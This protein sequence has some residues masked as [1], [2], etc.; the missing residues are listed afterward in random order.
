MLAYPLQLI[1]KGQ[2]RAQFDQQ[3]KIDI[4]DLITTEHSE[5]IPRTTLVQ[6]A[7]ESPEIKQSPNT[8]KATGKR[9]QQ[10]QKQQQLE[11]QPPQVSVPETAFHDSGT[12]PA[13]WQF[14][15]VKS[16]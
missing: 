14:L 5:Y 8:S 1:L 9:A 13:V 10:R 2:L 16:Y 11:N 3:T 12:T 7:A 6:A 4:L 15:E